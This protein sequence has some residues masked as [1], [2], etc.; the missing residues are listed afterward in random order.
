[1]PRRIIGFGI[2][3]AT[4]ASCFACAGNVQPTVT[5]TTPT[6]RRVEILHR[7]IAWAHDSIPLLRFPTP[8]GYGALRVQLEFCSGKTRE[9]WPKLYVAPINPLHGP[10]GEKYVGF[11]A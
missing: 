11:Y 10:N 9:G 8:P 3:C 6:D 2:I 1:M 4:I 5:P 7:D